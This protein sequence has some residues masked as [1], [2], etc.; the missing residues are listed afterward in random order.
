[1]LASRRKIGF[2]TMNGSIL[3]QISLLLLHLW[4]MYIDIPL[5]SLSMVAY[6]IVPIGGSLDGIMYRSPVPAPSAAFQV[7]SLADTH[8]ASYIYPTGT[9]RDHLTRL[10]I[11]SSTLALTSNF[12]ACSSA[13]PS[14]H[15]PST[16]VKQLIA[17]HQYLRHVV[18]RAADTPRPTTLHH[19]VPYPPSFTTLQGRPR[20]VAPTPSSHHTNRLLLKLP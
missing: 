6:L 1:M 17:H 10:E 4:S 8:S 19:L 3:V 7:L 16:H 12:L 13:S 9:N 11:S 2:S 20:A 18:Q 5:I 14:F 15:N